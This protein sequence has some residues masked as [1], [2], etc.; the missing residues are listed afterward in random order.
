MKAPRGCDNL[1][2]QAIELAEFNH[3]M[4]LLQVGKR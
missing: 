4:P 3:F 1:K 2:V